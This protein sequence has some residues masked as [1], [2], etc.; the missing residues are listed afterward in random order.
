[1]ADQLTFIDEEIKDLRDNEI[2]EI[3]IEMAI[4]R[5][6]PEQEH[7]VIPHDGEPGVDK[8]AIVVH[9]KKNHKWKVKTEDGSR[10]LG[11][12]SNSTDAYKQLYAIEMSK[13]RHKK[14]KK[15]GSLTIL[16]EIKLEKLAEA[17]W[18]QKQRLEEAR[19]RLKEKKQQ[20]FAPKQQVS[21]KSAFDIADDLFYKEFHGAA[22]SGDAGMRFG[23]E[24]IPIAIYSKLMR[25]GIETKRKGLKWDT[26][27]PN[28]FEIAFQS[29][30]EAA[31]AA[32]K[33]ALMHMN[34]RPDGPVNRKKP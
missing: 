1:M 26:L 4:Q 2:P 33:R 9:D 19:Q 6:Y 5:K 18:I 8:V 14:K 34:K 27:T 17:D 3:D 16:Q 30:A 10:T 31:D 7:D 32:K 25:P 11:T 29:M 22:N 15:H 23:Y 28:E 20:E 24:R 13:K 12:H 21:S